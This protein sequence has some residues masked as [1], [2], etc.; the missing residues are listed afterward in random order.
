M[1]TMKMYVILFAVA[2]ML[3]PVGAMA[4][5]QSVSDS[6]MQAITGQAGVDI[7]VSAPSIALGLKSITWGDPDGLGGTL[8][9]DAGYVNFSVPTGMIS[10]ITV[11][12]FLLSIDVGN[13]NN[14]IS[15][16]TETAVQLTLGAGLHVTLDAF[17]V[18]IFFDSQNAV[19]QDYMSLN[20][21]PYAADD[22]AV[23]ADSGD[24]NLKN[25]PTH[26][27]LGGASDSL[28]AKCVG[29]F[30]ISGLDVTLVD[31]TVITISAH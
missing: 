2:L 23:W 29:I 1:K 8:N 17:M 24:L 15:N 31:P 25:F 20:G 19:A 11:S 7:S 6:E 10:H 12:D 16:G 30:G 18:G 4:A 9:T 27:L 14:G 28:Q 13:A 21:N 5:M 26:K 3:V 22:Y